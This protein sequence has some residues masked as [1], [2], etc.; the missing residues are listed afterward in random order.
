[1]DAFVYDERGNRYVLS[2][3]LGQGGQGVVYRV[4]RGVGRGLAVKV[5]IDPS[6][7]GVLQD[8]A[9]YRSY[10]RKLDRILA[11][12]E[13]PNLAMPL[14]P[15]QKPFCGYIMRL[16]EGME[17]FMHH[18]IPVNRR[19]LE[20][21]M[22]AGGGLQKRLAVLRNLAVVLNAL[23]N[24]GILY[25]DLSPGNVFISTKSS[26]AEVWLID[27]D[28]LA[29]ENDSFRNF[30]TPSYRAPE[31]ARGAPDTILSDRYS[32]AL[33]AYEYLTFSKPFEGTM[34]DADAGEEDFGDSI[35]E[36]VERGEVPYVHE[37]GTDNRARNGLSRRMDLVM[38]PEVEALFLQTFGEKGRRDPRTRPSMRKWKDVL[39]NACGKLVQCEKGHWYLGGS[40][41]WCTEED[42]AASKSQCYRLRT[43]RTAYLLESPESETEDEEAVKVRTVRELVYEMRWSWQKEPGRNRPV[44]VPWRAFGCRRRDHVPGSAAF[45]IRSQ[46]TGCTVEKIFDPRLR[47]VMKQTADSGL[48]ALRF[49]AVYW[50]TEVEFEI[51]KDG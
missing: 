29:Y 14:A 43:Y 36:R 24:R 20:E 3:V 12:P 2:E 40:C 18:L 49:T 17:E 38:T 6:T 39:E 28:N 13:T 23:H 5:L 21:S 51:A 11:L 45:E 48:K 7:G 4:N 25:G 46:K 31:V 19:D 33:L 15:L 47:V 30:G 8:E 26:E 1:M 44:P 32:F 37:P 35:Y 41:P 27:V 16:M 10:L 9:A 42:R 22:C 50:G 34:M